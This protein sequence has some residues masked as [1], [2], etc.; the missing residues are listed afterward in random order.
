MLCLEQSLNKLKDQ[1]IPN[2]IITGN[3]TPP[4]VSWPTFTEIDDNKSLCQMVSEPSK[5]NNTLDL[6]STTQPQ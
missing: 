5:F 3:F 1:H 6:V 4:S 2:T